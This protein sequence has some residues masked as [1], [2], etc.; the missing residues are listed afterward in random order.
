MAYQALY[1]AW[2]P[3]RFSEIAGQAHITRTL[4]NA[5]DSGRIAHAYLFSGP[6]GTGKTTTAK[7]LAKAVNCAEREGAEPCNRC[8]SCTSINNGVSI[9]V[10]EIDAA[11]NRGIDEIRELREQIRFRPASSPY[12]VYIVDEVHMLTGEAFN[13]LLKTLEE[14]PRHVIFVLATTEVHKVPL[15]IL[16]RCQRFEFRRISNEDI[17]DRLDEIIGFADLTVEDGVLELIARVSEGSLR[18]ALSVLDQASALGGDR[19]TMVDLYAILGTV[20]QDVLETLAHRLD[21]NDAAGA[22]RLLHEVQNSKDL[23]LFA[24]EFTDYLR[25]LLFVTLEGRTKP[26]LDQGRTLRLL[27]LFAKAEQEMRF[28]SRQ[29][30]PLELAVVRFVRGD[31]DFEA[32]VADLEQRLQKLEEYVGTGH[33]APV[34]GETPAGRD[35]LPSGL[36]ASEPSPQRATTN[37]A[38]RPGTQGRTRTTAAGDALV[39]ETTLEDLETVRRRWPEVLAACKREQYLKRTRPLALDGITLVVGCGDPFTLDVFVRP[40]NLVVL[41]EALNRVLA[42]KWRIKC[43]RDNPPGEA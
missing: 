29:S 10:L 31:D 2:R 40:Q 33:Q 25:G 28:A 21:A 9:D 36:K 34:T 13:A 30:L 4:V 5:V 37:Q 16:S 22:L 24:R 3:Q 11:S 12:K 7:V 42:V 39:S 41:E 38:D 23:R 1:R 35:D 18:D 32:R 15:T 6:R 27:S 19:I 14:P 43:V 20:G 26:D 17:L 8:P